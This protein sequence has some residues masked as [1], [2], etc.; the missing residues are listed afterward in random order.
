MTYN[1]SF[2]KNNNIT[3]TQMKMLKIFLLNSHITHTYQEATACKIYDFT[4]KII[5]NIYYLNSSSV[6]NFFTWGLVCDLRGDCES[7]SDIPLFRLFLAP[8]TKLL[9]LLSLLGPSASRIIRG[10]SSLS[11]SSTIVVED[12]FKNGNVLEDDF[13]VRDVLEDDFKVRD[14]L[15]DDLE[16]GDV[17]EDDFDVDTLLKDDFICVYS[18]IISTVSLLLKDFIPSG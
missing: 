16:D 6:F 4:T 2:I 17:L 18:S 5:K 10:S 7:E 11:D 9:Q 3:N 14:V 1:K 8:L 15:E 13:K 12:D